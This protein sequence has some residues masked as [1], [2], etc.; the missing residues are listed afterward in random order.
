MVAEK[1]KYTSTS[2]KKSTVAESTL[3]HS[4]TGYRVYVGYFNRECAEQIEKTF[5][6]YLFN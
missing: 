5:E 3:L 4:I 6:K 2:K 1:T